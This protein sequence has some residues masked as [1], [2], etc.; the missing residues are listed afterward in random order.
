M[1]QIRAYR[2]TLFSREQ[3]QTVWKPLIDQMQSLLTGFGVPNVV[4]RSPPSGSSCG[5]PNRPPTSSPA[6]RNRPTRSIS[7]NTTPATASMPATPSRFRLA[8]PAPV[9]FEVY[10]QQLFDNNHPIDLWVLN[11]LGTGKSFTNQAFGR[12]LHASGTEVTPA[13]HKYL[14]TCAPDN[15]EHAEEFT[16]APVPVPDHRSRQPARPL[17]LHRLL[18]HRQR[19]D[20]R[21]GEVRQRPH[22]RGQAAGAPGTARLQPLLLLSELS[23]SARRTAV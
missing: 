6:C 20:Q 22:T 10:H 21:D 1:D 17:R 3:Q 5:S 13:G 23:R 7:S 8:R 18:Q 19:T 14:Y 15:G 16:I 9:N 11:D 4:R 2:E 12:N